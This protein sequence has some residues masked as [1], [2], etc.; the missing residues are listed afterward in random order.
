MTI[1]SNLDAGKLV[2]KYDS[3]VIFGG[4][5]MKAQ[6]PL[7]YITAQ[8]DFKWINFLNTWVT[9]QSAAGFFDANGKKWHLN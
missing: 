6:R 9:M 5:Q 1:T 3:L 4:G 7:A 8:D 2:Q